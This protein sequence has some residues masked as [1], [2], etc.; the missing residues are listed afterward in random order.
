MCLALTDTSAEKQYTVT[1]MSSNQHEYFKYFFFHQ[2][3]S[4]KTVRC[5]GETIFQLHNENKTIERIIEQNL[6]Q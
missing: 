3:R 2:V 4:F 5:N 1:V 6:F